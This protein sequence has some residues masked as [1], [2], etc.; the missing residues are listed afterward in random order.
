[1]AKHYMKSVLSS[2]LLSATSQAAVLAP[3]ND[4]V[5]PSSNTAQNPL[6]YSGGNTPYFAGCPNVNGVSNDVP[7]KCTV[8]QAAYVVRHGSRFPDTGSYDSWVGIQEK[9]QTAVK[10]HGFEARGSLSFISEWS[11]VLT[12]PTLQM[13]SESMTGWKEDG[14]PFYVWANQ[15]KYPI[16]ESRVVQ[17]ARAFV[18]GY[19]YEFAETY[20]TVVSVNST[21][22]TSAIGNSLGPSD[23]CPTFAS[24][25]SGGDNV[26]N[27]DATWVPKTLK[28]LN[29]LVSGNLTF[30]ETDILFFPYLCAYESQIRG[31]LSPWCN[32]FTEDELRNYAYSQ[33]LSYYY[34]VGPGADGPASVLF[35]PFLHSLTT[36]L[37]KGPGQ[38]GTGVDGDD[39]TVPNLIMA[40]LNDNQIAEMTAAMGVFDHESALPDDHIPANQLYNVAHFITMRGTVAFETLNCEV[41]SKRQFSNETYIRVLF[42]DAVYPIASCQNG[43]GKSCLL[44]EYAALIE[45]KNQ[46]AGN[47]ID[48]CNVTEASHPSTVAGASFFSDLSLNFLTFVK[49]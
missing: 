8:Q 34:D 13:A 42:N 41:E 32:V 39:F 30:D 25:S 45:K 12:N 7:D 22:S 1:M 46:D 11:P 29:S 9:V 24:T 27:F 19:L 35:L 40:F 26:T 23:S 37:S 47:F 2:L 10:G 20:G 3:V 4:I 44:S 21:G 33:D 49:P 15:Y 48:Y 5:F 18:N 16:N 28:R 43:P 36:L 14:N 31:N 38:K 17:T 6:Q